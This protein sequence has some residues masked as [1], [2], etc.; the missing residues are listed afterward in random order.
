VIN[1]VNIPLTEQNTMV[2]TVTDI[3]ELHK[4]Q[5]D[6]VTAK[7][8]AEESDRLK[9]AFLANMS[10][11]IR[12]PLNGIIGFSELLADRDF[13]ADQQSE[14]AEII[15]NSGNYLL[16]IINDIMDFSK[17]EA[18]QIKINK[19]PFVTQRLIAELHKEFSI[20]AQAKGIELRI[21]PLIP[22]EDI[23]IS[24]DENRLRQVLNNLVGNAIKFTSEGYVELGIKAIGDR[25]QFCVSDS[26]IGIPEEYHDKIFERFRQ[27]ELAESRK[28]GGNG[29][30]LAISKSL[31]EIMGGEIWIE[32]VQGKGS[33]FYFSIPAH[34][35][36]SD[37]VCPT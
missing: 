29:L 8:K 23:W 3:T 10:H 2:S 6:L 11:E 36:V 12:T 26:G 18:K 19:F 17:I 4:S 28:Y 37:N 27:V 24:S 32:S 25:V 14:F 16:S 31:I 33:T 9:S 7:E 34:K 30:G 21:D 13:D 22:K 15:V 1:A 35:P 5:N 20:V